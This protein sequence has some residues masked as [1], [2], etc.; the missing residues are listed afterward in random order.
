[1]CYNRPNGRIQ[2]ILQ[3]K[4]VRQGDFHPNSDNNIILRSS[5]QRYTCK[6]TLLSS[7]FP[8]QN[9]FS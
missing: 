1:M 3:R 2:H 9:I 7:R 5:N 4:E 6:F 8:K